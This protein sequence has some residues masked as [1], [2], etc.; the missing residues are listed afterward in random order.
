MIKSKRWGGKSAF[1]E[2]FL[3]TSAYTRAKRVEPYAYQTNK[4]LLFK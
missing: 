2:H 1:F 4:R 3:C